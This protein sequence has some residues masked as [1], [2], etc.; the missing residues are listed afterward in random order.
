LASLPSADPALSVR[1]VATQATARDVPD[2]ES[3]PRLLGF[4]AVLIAM[5]PMAASAHGPS[6]QKVVETIDINAPAEKVWAGVSNYKDFTWHPEI[7]KSQATDGMEPEKT[8]RSLTFK[9]GGIVTD[10]LMAN[11]P[12]RKYISFMTA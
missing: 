5:L 9:M 11:E 3:K 12:D 6:R 7:E 4:F 2:G 10:K 8:T 1:A